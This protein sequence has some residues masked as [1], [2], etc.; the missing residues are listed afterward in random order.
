VAFGLGLDYFVLSFSTVS[1]ESS[2]SYST[3][4]YFP[5]CWPCLWEK[6]GSI[7]MVEYTKDGTIPLLL[8]DTRIAEENKE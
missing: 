1:N 2:T 4:L 6:V 3:L 8:G 5:I 7:V